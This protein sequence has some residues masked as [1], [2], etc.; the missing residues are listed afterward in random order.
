[1]IQVYE[2]AFLISV[3]E[4]YFRVGLAAEVQQNGVSSL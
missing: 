4:I 2:Y 1:M 3:T